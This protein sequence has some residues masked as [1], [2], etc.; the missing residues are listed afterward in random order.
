MCFIF[1]VPMI[2]IEDCE[3]VP[4]GKLKVLVLMGGW[5]REREVS[6]R[7]G[8][9]V[10][11]NLDP[12]RYDSEG[13]DPAEGILPL[14]ERLK[15]VDLVFNMLH[16]YRGEDGCIQG[17]LELLN[18][19]YVGSGVLGSALA[20]NKEMSKRIYKSA[21]LHV[22]RYRLVTKKDIHLL[23]QVLEEFTPPVIIKPCNE[24]SSFGLTL[25]KD[26]NEAKKALNAGLDT[27]YEMLMEEYIKGREVTCC[28]L[29]NRVLTALPPIEIRPTAR[30]LFDYEAKYTPGMTLE[31][32]PAPIDE[33]I[34]ERVK[35]CAKRAHISLGLKVFSRTDMIIR[36]DE[37]YVLETNTLPGMTEQ[38]LFPLAARAIGWDMSRLLDELIG[39]AMEDS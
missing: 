23:N 14:I 25:A 6:L 8:N 38:S 21:G 26:M 13:F 4:M 17:L 32:C 15:E 27:G 37:I 35:D 28:I 7:S 24:G 29:G 9:A 20:M 34:Q 31:I 11:K 39:L 33:E 12:R 5:S 2:R 18:V 22:P 36:D 16:G 30:E 10:L 3:E 19:R 1:F